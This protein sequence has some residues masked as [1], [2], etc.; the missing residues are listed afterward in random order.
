M[1]TDHLDPLTTLSNPTV[2]GRSCYKPNPATGKPRH[3]GWS[4]ALGSVYTH[5]SRATLSTPTAPGPLYLHAQLQGHSICTHFGPLCLHP[6]LRAT[7]STPTAPG[8]FYLHPLW[9]TLSTPTAPGPLYLHPL[10]ATRSTPTAPGHSVY[11]HSS[12]ATLSAS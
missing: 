12:R 11:T 1:D 8:S 2:T 10:W 3:R 4:P 9:A 7:P 6:Q 5:S